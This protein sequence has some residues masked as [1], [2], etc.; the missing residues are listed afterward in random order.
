MSMIKQALKS[1]EEESA[2][3]G[4]NEA[5]CSGGCRVKSGGVQSPISHCVARANPVMEVMIRQKA[6][7]ARQGVKRCGISGSETPGGH[8]VLE[9]PH[10]HTCV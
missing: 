10:T 9:S 5:A 3:S 4:Q 7:K 8:G 6:A 1:D 2:R